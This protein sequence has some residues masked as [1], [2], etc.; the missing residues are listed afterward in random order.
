M[1]QNYFV[2]SFFFILLPCQKIMAIE[3]GGQRGLQT[4]PAGDGAVF[5]T[6][7]RT[8]L[9][10]NLGIGTLTGDVRTG[11]N[12]QTI[13]G[14]TTTL[15]LATGYGLNENLN[16]T[17]ELNRKST[18]ISAETSAESS[19]TPVVTS[20]LTH[21]QTQISAGPALWIGNTLLG[22]HASVTSWGKE[23]Y[24]DGTS[25]TTIDSAQI[26]RV[27]TFIGIRT[28]SITA[29]VRSVLYNDA[30]VKRTVYT[31]VNGTTTKDHKRR[32][33]AE[34]SLDARLQLVQ[35][36]FA[37]SLTYINAERAADG[38][39]N[40]DY[41]IYGFGGHHMASE[42]LTL[43]GGLQYT[44]AHYNNAEDASIFYDN[45]GGLQ[46]DLGLHYLIENYICT[47]GLGYTIPELLTYRNAEST[48]DTKI[49]RGLW[50]LNFGVIVKL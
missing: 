9:E 37:G 40:R 36:T 7:G 12:T 4:G 42:W 34:T 46:V 27:K 11:E 39:D 19:A 23:K 20:K 26:P 41:F 45:L 6:I 33:A 2:L 35:F 10:A 14:S 3:S 29:A 25:V 28:G 44:D 43:V 5:Q 8:D 30:R 38:P 49:E 16:F 32:M 24:R 22:A 47:F 15:T 31:E 17:I 48:E 50:D 1:L 13:S 18:E 21:S